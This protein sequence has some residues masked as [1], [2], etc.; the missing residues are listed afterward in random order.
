LGFELN[1]QVFAA[2]DCLVRS[3]ERCTSRIAIG[4]APGLANVYCGYGHNHVG[5][6]LA[7]ATARIIA[8]MMAGEDVAGAVRWCAPGRFG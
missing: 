2:S 1:I 6:T 5:L 4:R 3:R 7:T 8:R